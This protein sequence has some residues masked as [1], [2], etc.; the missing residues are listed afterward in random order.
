MSF[1]KRKPK[2]V[3]TEEEKYRERRMAEIV[4]HYDT[5]TISKVQQSTNGTDFDVV[6]V[7]HPLWD[8][9]WM[10]ARKMFDSYEEAMAEVTRN[11][12]TILGLGG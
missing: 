12:G 6:Y 11:N 5:W 3:L 7:P 8:D 9:E 4:Q 10:L 1:F 2:I